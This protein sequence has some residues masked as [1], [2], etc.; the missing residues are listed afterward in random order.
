[1]NVSSTLLKL[2]V[3]LSA[4]LIASCQTKPV[5]IR[6]TVSA[7]CKTIPPLTYAWPAQCEFGKPCADGE[8][9]AYDTEATT[10]AI[11]ADNAAKAALCP[12]EGQS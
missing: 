4:L 10:K 1:M 9:N 3:L 5:V 7:E 11:M 6:T 12:K 8:G 2:A